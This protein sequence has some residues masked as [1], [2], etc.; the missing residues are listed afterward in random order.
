MKNLTLRDDHQLKKKNKIRGI[1]LGCLRIAFL[2]PLEQAVK[3]KKWSK[4]C[5]FIIKKELSWTAKKTKSVF[6]RK[7]IFLSSVRIFKHFS[8]LTQQIVLKDMEKN[9]TERK[10]KNYLGKQTQSFFF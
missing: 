9:K 1:F 10:E 5:A 2:T 4:Q 3:A 7:T 8:F 6:D